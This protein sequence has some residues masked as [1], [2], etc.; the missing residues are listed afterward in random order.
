MAGAKDRDDGATNAMIYEGASISQLSKLF[1]MDAR[2]VSKKMAEVVPCG[3][4]RGF[5]VWRVKD[6]ARALVPPEVSEATILN[7]IANMNFR[8]LPAALNKEIWNGLRARLRFEQEQG[9]LWHTDRIAETMQR[10]IQAIR[11]TLL[12]VPDR[13]NRQDDLT[14]RQRD[15]VEKMMDELLHDLKQQIVEAMRA[16]PPLTPGIM[17]YG[18]EADGNGIDRKEPDEVSAIESEDFDL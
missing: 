15:L 7:Y 16:M 10:T 2:D 5:P 17:D 6:A 3:E 9:V 13:L 1:E 11:M 8:N 12:L 4:R 18:D 14:P